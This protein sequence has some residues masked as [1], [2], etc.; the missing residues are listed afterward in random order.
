MHVRK[1]GHAKSWWDCKYPGCSK[2][3]SSITYLNKHTRTVH[4][5]APLLQLL[6]QGGGQVG[7]QEGVQVGGQQGGGQVGGQ[8]GGDG[9]GMDPFADLPDRGAEVVL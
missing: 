6:Q 4:V 7:G 2:S 3:Y 9:L 5:L 1:S 8:E